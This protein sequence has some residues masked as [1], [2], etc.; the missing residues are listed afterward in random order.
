MIK[1]MLKFLGAF[2]LVSALG[3]API[4]L[5]QTAL[6][7]S[8]T[9]NQA[10]NGIA[11]ND[12]ISYTVQP[13]DNL[14]TIDQTYNTTVN[15]IVAL[16]PQI[17][18][19][20]LIYPGEVLQIPVGTVTNP[21]IPITGSGEISY[22]V[23]PGD[24]LSTIAQTYNTTVSAIQALNPQITDSSLIYSGEV[25]QILVGSVTNPIIPVTGSGEISF[26]VQPGDDLY[27][28]AQ[29][30]NTTVSAIQALNPQITNPGLIYSGEVLQ[31][32]VGAVSYP[33]VP[34]TGYGPSA[35]ITPSSGPQGS[36]VQVVV[37]GFPADTPIEIG[38]HK[39]GD[40]L[41]ES[42]ADLTTDASGNASITMQIPKGANAN[43]GLVWL[44]QVSTTSGE[45]ITINSSGFSITAK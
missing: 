29:A 40:R 16:N 27:A 19:P 39:L 3:F 33:T 4:S 43:I 22:T 41:I 23:Q 31:I 8:S 20:S 26:T 6:A 34:I 30:Y 37:S 42:T 28:I 24:N 45:S 38:L 2:A 13:G 36:D 44:A 15:A 5:A 10:T 25:L 17:T 7:A 35:V 21:V 11:T 1:H 18:D 9:A 12:P 32:P 14:F